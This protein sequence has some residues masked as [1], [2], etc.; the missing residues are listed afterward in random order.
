[1]KHYTL[2]IVPET[3]IIAKTCHALTPA[4]VKKGYDDT[5]IGA[6]KNKGIC[7]IAHQRLLLPERKTKNLDEGF[8]AFWAQFC[9]YGEQ[10]LSFMSQPLSGRGLLSRKAKRKSQKLFSFVKMAE[11]H[12]M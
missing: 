8:G 2:K 1:M 12:G 10:V 3:L 11:K 4:E 7:S 9:F 5:Y 6:K